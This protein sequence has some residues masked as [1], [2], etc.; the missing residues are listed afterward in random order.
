MKSILLFV[1]RQ[2]IRATLTLVAQRPAL[3][4]WF[5]SVEMWYN[6]TFLLTEMIISVWI[7]LFCTCRDNAAVS[8]LLSSV[9]M[10]A[11]QSLAFSY[12]E[13]TIEKG[14]ETFWI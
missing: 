2:R 3:F 12:S 9:L 11:S 5:L 6:S 14:E 10:P 4:H 1:A 13:I 7:S 8:R